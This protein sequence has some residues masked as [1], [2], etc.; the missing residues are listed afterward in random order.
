MATY[1]WVT[2][3]KAREL[4]YD[5]PDDEATL[6]DYLNAAYEECVAYLPDAT[7]VPYPSPVPS[8]WVLAQVQQARD[9]AR[10]GIVNPSQDSFG[11]EGLTVTAFP[12]SWHVKRLLRPSG[13]RRFG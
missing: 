5:A 6:A 11:G 2:S 7:L 10:A 3:E 9:L 12:M 8:S 4:W 1:G 13:R